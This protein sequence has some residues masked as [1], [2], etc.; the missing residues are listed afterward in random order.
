MKT[1]NKFFNSVI[2]MYEIC[3]SADAYILGFVYQH[4][5]Y[6]IKLK[7]LPREILTESRTSSKRGG[8][9]QVRIYIPASMKRD[10]ILSKK[11]KYFGSEKMLTLNPRYNKGDNFECL[12]YERYTHKKWF[13]DTTPYYVRGDMRYRGEEIQIKMDGA[14][15][16]NVNTILNTPLSALL[17]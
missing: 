11:A 17:R 14:E 8:V 9:L 15:L 10:W 3:S 6:Y 4:D 12:I 1:D 13:K 2:D 5:L 16:T 7:H